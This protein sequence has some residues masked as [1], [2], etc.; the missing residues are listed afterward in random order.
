MPPDPSVGPSPPTGHGDVPETPASL[1]RG[2]NPLLLSPTGD[3]TV[4]PA[5]RADEQTD[6]LPAPIDVGTG[7]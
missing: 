1:A 3:L 5:P 2:Q 6:T 7:I 4:T